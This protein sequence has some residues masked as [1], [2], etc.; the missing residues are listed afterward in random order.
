MVTKIGPVPAPG[1]TVARIR[2]GLT[3][4]KEA[5]GAL[6]NCTAV[7][8]VKPSPKIETGLPGWPV[9]GAKTKLARLG[10]IGL[11]TVH[12][13]VSNFGRRSRPPGKSFVSRS[14]R[15][16]ICLPGSISPTLIRLV[17]I[18]RPSGFKPRGNLST[19]RTKKNKTTS[20]VRP[21]AAAISIFSSG[22][23]ATTP[24]AMSASA[25]SPAFRSKGK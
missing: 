23:V 12:S 9:C 6:Q 3:T 22:S 20:A 5:A 19:A 16:L 15:A 11:S 8:F 17:P 1:G 7:T 2:F 10:T 4:V 13:G 25:A 14:Q 18:G 24:A 21:E